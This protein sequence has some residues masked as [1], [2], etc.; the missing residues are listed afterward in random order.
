M[1]INLLKIHYVNQ[2]FSICFLPFI[3]Y[4][5]KALYSIIAIGDIVENNNIYIREVNPNSKMPHKK[6]H[7]GF[8]FVLILTLLGSFGFAGYL[9][10]DAKEKIN[11]YWQIINAGFIVLFTFSMI[12]GYKN[13]FK[14]KTSGAIIASLIFIIWGAFNGLVMNNII[15]LPTQDAIPNFIN[16]EITKGIK[17]A[18]KNKIDYNLMYEFSDVTKQYDIITQDKNANTLTKNIKKINFTVSSGPNYDKLVII[19]NMIGMNI[20]DAI[21]II[22][23][24]FLNNVTVNFIES[25]EEQDIIIEQSRSGE[26][27]RNDELILTV[28]IGSL[29][30]LS[31]VKLVDLKNKSEFKATLYLKRNG[32]KYEI[33]KEFS[34]QIDKG[35][36][37]SSDPV[38]GAK[39]NPGDTV[40]LVISKGKEIKVPDLT[41]MQIS[42]VTKWIIENN[43]KIKYSDKYDSKIKL[44]QIISSSK[45]EGD[46]IEEGSTIEIIVSKGQLKMKSFKT[47]SEFKDYANKYNLKYEIKEE[48]SDDI[49]KDEIIKLSSAVNETVNPD[50]KIIIYV[51]KG[52]AITVPDLTNKNKNEITNLCS[53]N[54]IKC[55]FSYKYSSTISKGNSISQSIK[56]GEKI[57]EG[58]NINIIISN[59]KAP[60]NSSSNY[61]P[62][63]GNSGSSNN[64]GSSGNTTTPKP[65]CNNETL[66]LLP[67]NTGAQTKALTI[68]A[69]EKK[70]LKFSWISVSSCPS[71]ETASGAICKVSYD[72]KSISD[73][74]TVSTCKT[75][76]I[77]Y[78]N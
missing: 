69:N 75:I 7:K 14:K 57:G 55:S 67:G 24:N 31:A 51:S 27:K 41:N 47:L 74:A 5:F 54:N 45:K 44:G 21:K 37:I 77:T 40:K 78:V 39:I 3:F 18:E 36:V 62:S 25:D 23:K 52:K 53:K 28:S 16:K 59:G 34:N 68:K 43:L 58:E 2:V 65:T 63:D 4:N 64:N 17:W 72:G 35:D 15:M 49:K 33:T 11:M 71:G 13:C 56:A 66:N 46:V 6:S 61:K 73:G 76:T 20:D 32:I 29:D 42:D 8:N 60:V 10:Y 30:N 19:S 70:N 9:I 26:M 38:K 12:I 48:F 1:T 50:E 22:D